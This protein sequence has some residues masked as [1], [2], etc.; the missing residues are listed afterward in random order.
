MKR[1]ACI[2]AVL[3]MLVATGAAPACPMCK[4][5]I[6]RNDANEAASVPSGFNG[7]IF[8]MLGG[9][10]GVMGSVGWIVAKGIRQSDSRGV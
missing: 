5:S 4:D 8:V 7:S 3:F 1:I 6:A 10:F 2:L 9:L